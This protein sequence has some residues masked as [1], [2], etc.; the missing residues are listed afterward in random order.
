MST[1]PRTATPLEAAFITA[2]I[3]NLVHLLTDLRYSP[4]QLSD[5]VQWAEDCMEGSDPE[6]LPLCTAHSL[7]EEYLE[8]PD[9]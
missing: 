6:M 8:G 4:A 2:T 9:A 7:L 5:V 3:D 1:T